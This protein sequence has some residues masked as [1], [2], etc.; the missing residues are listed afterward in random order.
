[1]MPRLEC[2]V[3]SMCIGSDLTASWLYAY[4]RAVCDERYLWSRLLSLLLVFLSLMYN[5]A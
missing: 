2:P 1:M 4:M 3:G 5:N